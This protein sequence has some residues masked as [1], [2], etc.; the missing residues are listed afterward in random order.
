MEHLDGKIYVSVDGRQEML[1]A[2]SPRGAHEANWIE[3]GSHYEFR[4]YN[5]DHKKLVAK[6]A[7]T[8]AAPCRRQLRSRPVDGDDR[9]IDVGPSGR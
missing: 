2:G 6:V 8:M 3:A 7:V 5:T 9:N 1:F 4:L